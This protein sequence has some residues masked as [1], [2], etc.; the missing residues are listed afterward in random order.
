M[1]L[2]VHPSDSSDFEE[3]LLV[4]GVAKHGYRVLQ[5]TSGNV[6]NTIAAVLLEIRDQTG[7]IP[8]IYFEWTQGNPITNMFK[9]F[10]TGLGEIAPV[11]REVLRE[12]EPNAKRRPHIHVS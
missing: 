8:E 12:S 6:P 4:R 2:E 7:L 9:F 3:D 10:F 1:F 5:V 11:A